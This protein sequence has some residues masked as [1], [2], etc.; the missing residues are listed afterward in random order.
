MLRRLKEIL[1]HPKLTNVVIP[2]E[3]DGQER[4][5]YNQAKRAAVQYLDDIISSDAKGN[6]YLN[7]ISKINALRMVCNL[8]SSTDAIIAV[9]DA[10]PSEASSEGAIDA[11]S[12]DAALG[13]M[14]ELVHHDDDLTKSTSTCTI[15]GLDN[16]F[17]I[18]WFGEPSRAA[19]SEHRADRFDHHQ[20][21]NSMSV[22]LLRLHRGSN[23]SVGFQTIVHWPTQGNR[24]SSRVFSTKVKDLVSDLTIQRQAKKRYV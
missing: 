8:G 12:F 23:A 10:T 5:K 6:G 20:A 9:S 16:G 21:I 7:A 1:R 15:C 19:C 4:G 24:K 11:E 13:S 17:A 18:A 22:L 14:D 3:F 2:M